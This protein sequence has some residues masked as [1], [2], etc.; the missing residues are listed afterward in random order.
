MITRF[1]EKR[2]RWTTWHSRRAAQK[3]EFESPPKRKLHREISSPDLQTSKW[4]PSGKFNVVGYNPNAHEDDFDI[5]TPPPPRGGALLQAMQA[6]V[7]QFPVVSMLAKSRKI[8]I[9]PKS[10]RPKPA[11]PKSVAIG[12]SECEL[13]AIALDNATY[14]GPTSESN[15]RVEVFAKRNGKKVFVVQLNGKQ[16][17][18]NLEV[19]IKC[20]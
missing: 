2:V 15:P 10:A 4:S 5:S 8:L 9:R 20:F 17:G 11:A 12:P 1:Q 7:S 6:D 13:N 3:D 16:F 19:A 18:A 14:I